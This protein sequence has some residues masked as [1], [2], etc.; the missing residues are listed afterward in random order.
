[1]QSV[2][3]FTDLDFR[4]QGLF[5]RLAQATFARAEK[6]GLPFVYGFPNANSAPGFFGRLAWR[7]MSAFPLLIAPMRTGYFSRYLSG[8]ARISLPD[9]SFRR[10]QPPP[11]P[12]EA[13]VAQVDRFDDQFAEVWQSFAG[14]KLVAV[15][16]DATYLRWRLQD[17][18]GESYT[19]IG[20][21]R[22]SRLSAYATYCI[23]EKHGG[24]IG[25][26]MELLCRSGR[27]SDARFLLR[28]TLAKLASNKADAVLAL[29]LPHSKTFSSYI[30]SG[31]IPIPERLRPIELHFG[32]RVFEDSVSRIVTDRRSWYLSYLDSDTV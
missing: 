15:E 26:L 20:L 31:F 8:G 2:D 25:Y 11:V 7:R 1:M 12:A 10:T 16:R 3:T 14:N 5:G 27:A 21:F 29:C 30:L 6:S 24:K 23:K 9:I 4:G 19:T 32:V 17:K 28:H 13:R 22:E 18:P